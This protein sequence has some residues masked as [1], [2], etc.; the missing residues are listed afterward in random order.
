VLGGERECVW[1]VGGETGEGIP[2]SL[3]QICR[4]KGKNKLK[5]KE[6]AR[7]RKGQLK[8]LTKK[9]KGDNRKK[10]ERERQRHTHVHAYTHTRIHALIFLSVCW[11]WEG[12][13]QGQGKKKDKPRR[14]H[15]S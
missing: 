14:T 3:K 1:C 5:T 6:I 13:K 11:A 8:G 15:T 2:N 10:S 12:E 7:E 4:M 9:R